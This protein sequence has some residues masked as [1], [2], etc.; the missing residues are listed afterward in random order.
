M[1]QPSEV[2][3]GNL[4]EAHLTGEYVTV[5]WLVIKHLEGG[6]I[7]NGFDP[8]VGPV[9]KPIPL[10]EWWL[11]KLGF[12]KGTANAGTMICFKKSKYT[13]A[14]WDIG[15]W[16]MWIATV[17]IYK[18]IKHVHELQNLYFALTGSELEL[19]QLV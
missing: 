19:K 5:D 14:E 8:K 3:V 11:D 15:E 7:Q 10:N 9:Y 18:K 16:R 13:I 6:N 4:L 2:R 17:D 1:V 12:N